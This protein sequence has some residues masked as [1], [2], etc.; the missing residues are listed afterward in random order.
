MVLHF[1]SF[2]VFNLEAG[3]F[4]HILPILHYPLTFYTIFIEANFDDTS[5]FLYL[6]IHLRFYD[7]QVTLL[8]WQLLALGKI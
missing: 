7:L 2:D 5:N 1:E 6:N 3:L 4:D 8:T